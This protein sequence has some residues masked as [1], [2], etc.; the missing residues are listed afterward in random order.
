[1]V[2]TP[3]LLKHAVKIF[4]ESEVLDGASGAVRVTAACFCGDYQQDWPELS[5]NW[6]TLFA[7][8]FDSAILNK[9]LT[10]LLHIAYERKGR[11]ARSRRNWN[12]LF[13]P[14]FKLCPKRG[15]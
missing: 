7:G 15:G 14:R 5:A 9:R 12:Y 10:E 11:A 8:V 2:A 6:K 1:M 13:R 3:P 4:I